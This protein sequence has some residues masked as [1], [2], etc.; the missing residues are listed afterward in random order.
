MSHWICSR[1]WR[2][3]SFIQLRSRTRPQTISSHFMIA[4]F[5]QIPV[6]VRNGKL[7]S[8]NIKFLITGMS[9]KFQHEFS[10]VGLVPPSTNLRQIVRSAYRKKSPKPSRFANVVISWD[11]LMAILGGIHHTEENSVRGIGLQGGP[12]LVSLSA[13]RSESRGRGT[14]LKPFEVCWTMKRI[15]LKTNFIYS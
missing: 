10:L 1:T 7:V 11:N 15:Y 2:S 13:S 6:F 4:P 3:K 9:S 5:E 12:T 8:T 14:V